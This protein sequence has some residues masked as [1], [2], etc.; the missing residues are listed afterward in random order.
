MIKD[1]GF[2]FGILAGVIFFICSNPILSEIILT[3]KHGN[4]IQI[5]LKD[6]L[7]DMEDRMSIRVKYYKRYI[8]YG[9]VRNEKG[10]Y[11][12]LLNPFDTEGSNYPIKIFLTSSKKE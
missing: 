9:E 5:I 1:R 3:Q 2:L 10:R 7:N 8:A 11:I 6:S 12:Y 4:Q